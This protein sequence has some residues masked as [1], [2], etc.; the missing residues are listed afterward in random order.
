MK[1]NKRMVERYGGL[2]RECAGHGIVPD[3][4]DALLRCER[5][6]RR[7]AERECGDGSSWAIER[8]DATG[9]PYNVYHG[10][11]NGRRYPIADLE[12]GALRRATAIAERH[13]L[14]AY[15][16]TDPR[17]CMLYLVRP[18]DTCYTRGIVVCVE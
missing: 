16:Q 12:A 7:W 6:L 5:R 1:W 4:V 15:H 10:P 14:T 8:D 9:K 11:G 2:L 3:E 13:G 17:G 18:G